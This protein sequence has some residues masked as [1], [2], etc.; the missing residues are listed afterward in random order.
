MNGVFH[1]LGRKP[2]LAR[3]LLLSASFETKGYALSPPEQRQRNLGIELGP[4]FPEILR[5]IGVREDTWWGKSLLG[6]LTYYRPPLSTFGIRY[7]FNARRW[8]GPDAG[9]KPY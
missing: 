5:A 6:L 4:N 2:G 7:D 9:N 3:F 1:R 8:R